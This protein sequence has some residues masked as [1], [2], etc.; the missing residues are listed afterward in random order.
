MSMENLAIINSLTNLI[1][2]FQPYQRL[3]KPIVINSSS[4]EWMLCLKEKQ[5][6]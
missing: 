4:K 1:K 6:G 5:Q 3:F 2:V